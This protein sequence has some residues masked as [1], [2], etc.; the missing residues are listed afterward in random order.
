MRATG[1]GWALG[2][3]R[4]G[5]LISPA[6][7]GLLLAWQWQVTSIFLAVA[8]PALLA[9]LCVL[10]VGLVSSAMAREEMPLQGGAI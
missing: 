6:L 7:G 3:G 4:F 10:L 2:V 1:V 8:L 9:A 5:S